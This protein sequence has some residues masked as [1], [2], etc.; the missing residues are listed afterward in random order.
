MSTV[1][2]AIQDP[3]RRQAMIA[4]GI[5]EL[6][7]ELDERSGVTAMAM[8]AGYK[9]LRKVRPNMIESNLDRLLPMWAP[10]LDPHVSAGRADGSVDAHFRANA[11]SIAEGLLG[12]T[13]R[14]AAEANN[15]LA[16]KAYN[17]LRPKA[18]DQV[19]AGMPRLARL[20]DKHV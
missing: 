10:V 4:D 12:A 11:D 8:R 16:V 15:Q 17:K 20:V 19:V 7:A 14:R 13:D 2:E 3:T 1:S 6:E 9:T 5:T 18:K